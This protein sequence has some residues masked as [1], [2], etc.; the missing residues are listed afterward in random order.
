MA[1]ILLPVSNVVTNYT[2]PCCT[3]RYNTILVY[4]TQLISESRVMQLRLIKLVNRQSN[5][6]YCLACQYHSIIMIIIQ[7]VSVRRPSWDESGPH[8]HQSKCTPL[9]PPAD[10]VSSTD[11][12]EGV[13]L[14]ALGSVKAK[15]R[16]V[17]P[18]VHYAV[19]ISPL[20]SPKERQVVTV[21][22]GLGSRSGRTPSNCLRPSL[23]LFIFNRREGIIEKP[24]IVSKLTLWWCIAHNNFHFFRPLILIISLARINSEIGSYFMWHHNYHQG[25]EFCWSCAFSVQM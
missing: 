5:W 13:C 20:L 19:L 14:W 15:Q 3:D 2:L 22:C 16:Y 24:K 23:I 25:R 1:E 10:N 12:V 18:C 8:C 4:V 6:N 11:S 17:A 7:N 9:S 21:G